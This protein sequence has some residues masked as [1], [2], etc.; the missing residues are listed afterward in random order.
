MR[1]V[2]RTSKVSWAVKSKVAAL[3][4]S[5]VRQQGAAAYTQLL[6]QLLG[7]A[8]NNVHQAE[9]ACMVLHFVSEDMT[10]FDVSQGEP[11]LLPHS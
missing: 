3:L 9:L 2:C 10:H 5:V 7:N 1:A 4:A 6:P 8:E 11:Y